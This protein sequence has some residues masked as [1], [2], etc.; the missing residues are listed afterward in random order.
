MQKIKL[1]IKKILLFILAPL[2]EKLGYVKFNYN[3]ADIDRS[4]IPQKDDLIDHL[5][6]VLRKYEFYPDLI[7][8]VGANHG[9]WSRK[10][11]SAFP[12][13]AFILIEPQSWL[14]NSFY[15]MLDDK[16]IY[17]PVGAGSANGTFTFTINSDRDDSSS[18]FYKGE[19][20]QVLGYKQIEIPVRTLNDIISDYGK[21]PDMIKIDAEGLDLE[22]LEGSSSVFGKTEIFFIEADINARIFDNNIVAVINYMNSKGYRLFEITDL[23]RPFSSGVLW[24]MELVFIKKGGFLDSKSYTA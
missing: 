20:A 19:D 21:I 22:V 3:Y 18:F 1:I 15:D 24:L 12:K 6:E 5:C 16:T 14:Q 10:W 9:T 8:D 17:Y 4:H 7:I 11:K 2:I 23:N 13:S